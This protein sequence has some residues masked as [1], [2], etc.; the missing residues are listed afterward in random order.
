MRFAQLILALFLLSCGGGD[1]GGSTPTSPTTPTTPTPVATSITISPSSLSLGAIGETAT[2]T[3]TVKDQSGATM[4]GA[5]VSWATSAASVA[6]VSSSGTVTSVADG[7]ATITAT[8]GSASETAAV[9]VAQAVAN[10]ELVYTELIFTSLGET[11][12]LDY[13]VTDTNGTEISDATVTWTTSDSTIA[14]VSSAG[15]V[16]AVADGTATVT[17]TSGSAT[18]TSAITICAFRRRHTG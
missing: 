14:T 4:S 12:Q 17:A 11:H 7:S 3:A 5:S 2:L 15:L 10:I 1:G 18:A 8:F 16:T 6:T 9:T 13:M